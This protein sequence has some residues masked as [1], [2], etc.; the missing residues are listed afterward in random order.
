MVPHTLLQRVKSELGVHQVATGYGLTESGGMASFTG[1]DDPLELVAATAGRAVPGAEI[2]CVRADG[3]DA[4][5]GEPGEVY[6]RTGK[7][8]LGY[9]DDPDA[10]AAVLTPDGWLRSGDVGWLD[11]AGNLRITDRLKDMYI[12]GGFN[13]YP[14]EIERVL[15][16]YPGVQHCA[17]IG[18]PDERLG[19]VGRAFIVP[20]HSTTLSESAIL[21]WCKTNF[22]NYKVPRS[23][24]FVDALPLNA[25]G[26]VMKHVLRD[27]P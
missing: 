4:P 13:C 21:A 5:I 26:K 7:N 22:A 12:V 9:L 23:I 8:M 18:I 11:E 16:G 19:E 10:T 1:P 2:K 27:M 6:I 20:A 14:A 3:M 24:H 15:S 17:V 25:S